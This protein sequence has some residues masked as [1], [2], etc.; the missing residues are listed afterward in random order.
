V[1]D[2]G[3]KTQPTLTRR[4][5]LTAYSTAFVSIG[6]LPMIQMLVP[7][8]CVI[9]LGFTAT[10]IG[11]AAGARSLLATFFS[12]HSGAVLDRLGVRPVMTW[13]AAI[14]VILVLL[15]P[16]VPM[17]STAVAVQL[18]LIVILQLFTGF[19]HTIGW[20]GA[21]TQIGQLTAGSPKYMGRFTAVAGLSNFFTPP[22]AGWAWDVGQTTAIGGAW[23]A[24]SFIALWN[25][26]LWI[27]ISFMPVPAAARKPT[28]P[29][30]AKDLLPSLADYREAFRLILIP[31]V[32]FVVV[33]SFLM[34]GL[35]Q[36]RMNFMPLYMEAIGYEGRVI[37]LIIGLGFLVSGF[38]ALS[39]ERTR[40]YLA[41][42][43]IVLL[44]IVC[45]AIGNGLVPLFDGLGGL[46]FTTV[47]FGAGV[48]LGMAFVLSLLSRSVPTEQFGLSV[49]IRTTGNRFGATIVP[50]ITGLIIDLAGG[51]IGAGMIGTALLFITGAAI[52]ALL[53][54]RSQLIQS[55]F[56]KKIILA[57]SKNNG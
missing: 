17:V 5:E 6:M 54:A 23:A 38:T 12:I 49:G 18:A 55:T 47:I 9:E 37:G 15:Y 44:M 56:A 48:G 27:S 31:T 33:G 13:C 20:I 10:M 16:V 32:A 26:L 29:F 42:H 30:R 53:A 8:W 34:N 36:V 52:V 35:I 1:A 39:T 11:I 40:R 25:I 51:R 24:F 22:L 2:N 45:S 4:A 14:S 21:Q 28:R 41:P 46:A 57:D 7:L 50:P 19:F 3:N 43:W